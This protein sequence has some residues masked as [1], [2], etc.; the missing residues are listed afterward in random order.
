MKKL[1]Q[2]LLFFGFLPLINSCED[3]N[4][5]PQMAP[6]QNTIIPSPTPNPVTDPVL[7]PK[8]IKY[9]A[10]G[11]SY[12]VGQSV[13]STCRFPEQLMSK[14][15][16]TYPENSFSLKIIATT[17]WIT[18]N[19]IQAITQDDTSAD[20][21]LVT[22]LIGVNNQYQNKDFAIYTK[23]FVDLVNKGIAL[24]KGSKNN[25]VV[26]SIP[27]YAFTP[28]GV[29]NGNQNKISEEIN[30]YNNF[31]QQ[32][33]NNNGIAYIDITPITRQGIK[34]PNLVATDDLHPSEL[35]YSKFVELLFPK[36][37]VAL[38]N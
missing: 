28:F 3:A 36:V 8:A 24:G 21:D 14:L 11:D 19:L 5:K 10:L 18:T 7:N 9:L 1:I 4:N 38:Q 34:E 29:R 35:A 2:I 32:Y 22:L 16:L 26:V 17:G 27:D 25:L 23:E 6:V 37:K 20:Y 13:C 30:N 33:C 31:A 12:T 15:R